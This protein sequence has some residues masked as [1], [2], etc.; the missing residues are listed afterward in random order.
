MFPAEPPRLAADE[1]FDG[2]IVRGLHLRVER[3]DLVRVQ[4]MPLLAAGD[5]AVLEWCASEGRILLSPDRGPLIGYAFSRIN[6]GAAMAGL[7]VVRTDLFLGFASS[8]PVMARL[9][10]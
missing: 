10:K 4:D 9:A 1:N 6:A 3:L 2:R 7:V 8:S 5:P